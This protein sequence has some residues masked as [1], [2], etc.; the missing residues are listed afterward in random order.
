[1]IRID[2]WRCNENNINF[3][4]RVIDQS[5][6]TKFPHQ[7]LELTVKVL[8]IWLL[9]PIVGDALRIRQILFWSSS[10]VRVGTYCETEGIYALSIWCCTSCKLQ[11]SFI[12]PISKSET[13]MFLRGLSYHP[14][15]HILIAFMWMSWFL[16][17]T[18]IAANS[19]KRTLLVCE[20]CWE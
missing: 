13:I 17:N 8:L 4:Y 1:M 2:W 9:F 10:K 19:K 11:F 7:S 5:E 12:V 16:K 6:F 3:E 15:T 14:V 18:W 20:W